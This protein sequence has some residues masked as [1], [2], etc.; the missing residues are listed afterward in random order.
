MS[1]T[2]PFMNQGGNLQVT[3]AAI[4]TNYVTFAARPCLE[5]QIINCSGVEIVW[6]QDNDTVDV[7][8]PTGCAYTARGIANANQIKVRRRDTANTQIVI[9]ARW[10][11]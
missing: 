8:L 9:Q 1:Y 5:L 11:N 10:E 6:Q 2:T 3:T 4:G 7:P